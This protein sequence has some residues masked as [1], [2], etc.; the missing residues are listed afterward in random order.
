MAEF[1]I[2]QRYF[3]ALSPP[4]QDV[5]LGIGDDCALLQPPAGQQL[6]VTMDTLISERHFLPD[7]DPES[8]GHKSLAVNLSDLAAM[9]A[10][11]A[12]ALLSLSLPAA[13]DAWLQEF[14]R[15]FGRLASQYGVKL[16]G[17][18]TCQ[19]PLSITVQL[20][21]FV[22]KEKAML[23]GNARPGDGIYVTGTLG[24]AALALQLLQAGKNPGTLRSRLEIPQPRIDAGLCLADLG[25]ASCI[26]L[27]DG[28][29]SDLGHL[30]E[31]SGCGAI[32]EA[33]SLPLSQAFKAHGGTLETA[34]AGGD[35]YELCFTAPP[36]LWGALADLPFQVSRIGQVRK[37]QGV[38]LVDEKGDSVNLPRGWEHF[39]S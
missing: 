13:D 1:A 14:A 34:V 21:G 30:C 10:T 35:D 7:V 32:I 6:A 31:R 11:P 24:E 38:E 22:A 15:G 17:G 12:W 18:D 29:V 20:T 8:L 4:G 23:R 26:D 19:G 5:L 33:R 37:G 16:V 3:S 9:G 36:H 39:S 28:L 2:I 25:V 27:S